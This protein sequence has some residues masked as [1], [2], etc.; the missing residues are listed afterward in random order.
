MLIF[1]RDE[2]KDDL[3]IMILYN[4]DLSIAG[5]RNLRINYYNYYTGLQSLLSL[6]LPQVLTD[7]VDFGLLLL[8]LLILLRLL[9]L[10]ESFK[11]SIEALYSLY[12]MG[13]SLDIKIKSDDALVSSRIRSELL[14]LDESFEELDEPLWHEENMPNKTKRAENRMMPITAPRAINALVT[15]LIGS[16]SDSVERV[17]ELTGGSVGS[18]LSQLGSIKSHKAPVWHCLQTHWYNESSLHFPNGHFVQS[19]VQS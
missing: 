18:G 2:Q 13:L 3:N 7:L 5:M 11:K 17:A 10:A 6:C 9:P 15:G 14:L 12:V 16:L 1:I 4:T 8:P 19:G